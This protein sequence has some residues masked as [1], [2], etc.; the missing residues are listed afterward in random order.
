MNQMASDS[1]DILGAFLS[2]GITLTV[3][4]NSPEIMRRYIGIGPLLG[5]HGVKLSTVFT[6]LPRPNGVITS[7]CKNPEEV[8]KLFDLM[9][10]DEACLLGRYGERGIDWEY[11]QDRDISIYGTP[12]TIRIINQI[13]NTIQNK[14]LA[15]IGPYA[16]RPKY[17]G[18][19]TWDGNKLDGEYMNAQAALLHEGFEPDEYVQMLNFTPEEEQGIQKTRED[20]EAHIRKTIISFITGER[21]INSDSQWREYIAE[22]DILGLQSFLA[23]AQTA[24]DRWR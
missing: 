14:H 12:A 19:V 7:A 3:S 24:Y 6:P 8:F 16:S 5:P 23:A 9:L 21:N 15:Q 20:I 2:P 22:F 11:A 18:G 1:R 4:Q 10:S 13:W 17:S